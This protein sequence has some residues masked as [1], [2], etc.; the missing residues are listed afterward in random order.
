MRS[1]WLSMLLVVSSTSHAA[2]TEL[3]QVLEQVKRGSLQDKQ[4]SNEH[5][6]NKS[7]ELKEAQA[8]FEKAQ[9]QLDKTQEANAALE[10]KNPTTS[11]ITAKQ[12]STVPIAASVFRC[13]F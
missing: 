3:D 1:I 8:H 10:E 13:C 2:N 5:V 9:L 4:L 7:Y 12:T 6:S 11:T